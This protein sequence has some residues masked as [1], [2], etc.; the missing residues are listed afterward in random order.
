[1][2]GVRHVWV[3]R[4]YAVKWMPGLVIEWR[5]QPTQTGN[6]ALRWDALCI[7]LDGERSWLEWFGQDELK[8]VPSLPPIS[9]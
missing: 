1:M 9:P 3:R 7:V 6:G 2:D 4:N 5:S 8:P